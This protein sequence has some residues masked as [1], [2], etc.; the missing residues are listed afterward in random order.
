MYSWLLSLK[1][2]QPPHRSPLWIRHK[3]KQVLDAF[4]DRTFLSNMVS[5]SIKISRLIIC[6]NASYAALGPDATLGVLYGILDKRFEQ[7]PQSI[8]MASALAHWCATNEQRIA[9]PARCIVA[10]ILANLRER[11]DRWIAL[12]VEQF[13]L[14]ERALR[15]Q[16]GHGDSV[17]LSLLI[18]MTRQ[19]IRS[20]FRTLKILSS[21]S[22]F[23][24]R[25]TLPGLQ[26]DFCA[27]WNEMV[28]EARNEGAD[29]TPT[30]IL[31]EIRRVYI[32]LHHGTTATPTLFSASTGDDNPILSSPSSYPFCDIASHISAATAHVHTAPPP[33]IPLSVPSMSHLGQRPAY[34]PDAPQELTQG[35]PSTIHPNP[36]G[37]QPFPTAPIGIASDNTNQGRANTSTNRSAITLVPPSSSDGPPRHEGAAT[38]ITSSPSASRALPLPNLA[39]VAPASLSPSPVTSHHSISPQSTDSFRIPTTAR[40]PSTHDHTQDSNR[41]IPLGVPALPSGGAIGH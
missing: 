5:E 12:A 31:S 33:D 9:E 34:V 6:L 37:S 16:I 35:V 36:H 20:G 11:D 26:H 21:L 29:S 10:R 17:V 40:T 8:E 28:S 4:L 25:D 38:N 24:I 19:A 18:H 1:S 14:P 27:L 39:P 30:R 23:N 7:V 22:N 32:T 13:G 3:F 2:G 41:P 15:D